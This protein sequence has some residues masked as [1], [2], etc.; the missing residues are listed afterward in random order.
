MLV[1]GHVELG[2]AQDV[3]QRDDSRPV[4]DEARAPHGRGRIALKVVV[5][6]ASNTCAAPLSGHEVSSQRE[7][8][9]CICNGWIGA[10]RQTW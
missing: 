4:P 3:A 7:P 10:I 9:G 5:V 1:D 8:V 6:P 2:L